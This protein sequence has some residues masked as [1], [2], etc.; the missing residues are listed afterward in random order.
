MRIKRTS[1][2]QLTLP[3]KVV[4]RFPGIEYF[5]VQVDNARIV[6]VPLQ[7]DRLA[8]VQARM[9]ALR[10][11]EKDVKEAVAWVRRSRR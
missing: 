10:L 1:E 11:S 5:D 7:P 3:K 9:K 8:Q 6:L 4:D 2:N